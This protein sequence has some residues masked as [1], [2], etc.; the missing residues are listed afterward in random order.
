M[1]IQTS[2]ACISYNIPHAPSLFL[3]VILADF[4]CHSHCPAQ[5]GRHWLLSPCAQIAPGVLEE[6]AGWRRACG[7]QPA[8]PPA[9]SLLSPRHEPFLPAP[10]C[11]GI[12]TSKS[13]ILKWETVECRLEVNSCVAPLVRD[14][15]L[16]CL[17]PTPSYWQKWCSGCRIK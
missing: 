15:L 7:H 12:R 5:P 17:K 11:Q 8:P 6:P 9:H 3:P 4:E 10:I 14:M 13:W 1:N 16:M 2:V